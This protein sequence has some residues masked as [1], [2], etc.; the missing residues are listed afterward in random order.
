MLKDGTLTA[1]EYYCGPLNTWSPNLAD[2]DLFGVN[3]NGGCGYGDPLQ[4]DRALI[5]K[6]LFNGLLSEGMA[7]KVYGYAKTVEQTETN[8]AKMRAK[9]LQE[10][11]PAAQ[12]WRQERKR[13]AKGDI[14][15]IAAQTFA[16]SAELSDKVRDLYL[17]FW[18]LK[19]F[20]YS[21][22]GKVDFKVAS[23]TGFYYPKS[24][25]KQHKKMVESPAA[26]A[27]GKVARKPSRKSA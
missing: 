27:T 16:R 17:A 2:G 6:D 3:Y 12:W 1:E 15:P 26:R 13:A 9:R 24:P 10:S 4:R 20:P 11:V 21:D 22:T 19:K 23:P 7:R 18:D 14:G 25:Q 8:R 5:E